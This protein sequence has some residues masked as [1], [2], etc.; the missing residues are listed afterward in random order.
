MHVIS[1]IRRTALSSVVAGVL[2]AKIVASPGNC[3]Y[4]FI[5]FQSLMLWWTWICKECQEFSY[6]TSTALYRIHNQNFVEE[7]CASAAP[8]TF[9][10]FSPSTTFAWLISCLLGICDALSCVLPHSTG[11]NYMLAV[12]AV[13]F[14]PALC[15]R[16]V[17]YANVLLVCIFRSLPSAHQLVRML[18]LVSSVYGCF[19]QLPRRY[20]VARLFVSGVTALLYA[21]H[22]CTNLFRSI[23]PSLL[24]MFV[25]T[26][27]R[28]NPVFVFI[29]AS[30][31]A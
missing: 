13:A 5:S 25:V 2:L 29:I 14:S 28:T 23:P 31:L 19:I 22:E 21:Q 11:D 12:A 7:S 9:T 18:A 30:A 4:G 20:H 8:R 15:V 6:R 26:R 24:L 27:H 3:I 17:S 16:Y 10:Y 1:N